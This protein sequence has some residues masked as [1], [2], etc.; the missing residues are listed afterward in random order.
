M[1]PK[2]ND[3]IMAEDAVVRGDLYSRYLAAEHTGDPVV[4]RLVVK[5]IISELSWA[6][7]G[8]RQNY[9]E[10]TRAGVPVEKLRPVEE[11]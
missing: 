6:Q 1:S 9:I 4:R 11:I 2:S 10:A 7:H 3:E 5:A 8:R